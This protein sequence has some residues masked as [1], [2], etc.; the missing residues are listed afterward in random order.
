MI[1]LK[2]FCRAPKCKLSRKGFVDVAGFRSVGGRAGN[3][4]C[5][6]FVEG[7]AHVHDLLVTVNSGIQGETLQISACTCFSAGVGGTNSACRC[8]GVLNDIKGIVDMDK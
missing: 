7:M 1:V 3:C 5:L 4:F 6:C 2:L 8:K